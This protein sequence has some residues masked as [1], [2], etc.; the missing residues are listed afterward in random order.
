VEWFTDSWTPV[1]KSVVYGDLLLHLLCELFVLSGFDI[2]GDMFAVYDTVFTGD[3][4]L[5]SC[6]TNNNNQTSYKIV[7]VLPRLSF[8]ERYLI[9]VTVI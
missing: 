6:T 9:E 8:F 7:L 3:T 1:C 4:I 2:C 5:T